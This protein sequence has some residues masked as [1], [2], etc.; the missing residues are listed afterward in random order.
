M[1]RR[2]L[3]SFHYPVWLRAANGRDHH[4]H[5]AAI[6]LGYEIGNS[7]RL[8]FH[9]PDIDNDVLPVN[10]TQLSEALPEWFDALALRYGRTP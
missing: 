10:I 2:S 4:V 9:S 5:F 8:T 7:M 1:Q 3:Y 6:E